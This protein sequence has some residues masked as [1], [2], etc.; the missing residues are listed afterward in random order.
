MQIP[1]WILLQLPGPPLPDSAPPSLGEQV[2]LFVL[3][4]GL[5]LAMVMLV[6]PKK[7]SDRIMRT[8]FLR[9][10]KPGRPRKR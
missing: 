5:L 2:F 9:G 8:A 10:V 7:W 4:Y 6:I 1:L 3:F